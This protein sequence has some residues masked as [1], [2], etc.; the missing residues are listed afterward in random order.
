M[1]VATTA[2]HLSG[3]QHGVTTDTKAHE[4]IGVGAYLR[5]RVLLVHFNAFVRLCALGA[6]VL[7]HSDGAARTEP[8]S[9]RRARR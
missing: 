5:G 6:F 4:G 7:H 8:L 3:M 9:R 1:G 2:E